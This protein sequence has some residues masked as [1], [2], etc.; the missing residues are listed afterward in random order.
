MA[1]L[2]FAASRPPRRPSMWLVQAG[3]KPTFHAPTVSA[4]DAFTSLMEEEGALDR[5]DS[6]HMPSPS[7][8]APEEGPV[9]QRLQALSHAQ[10]A[11]QHP[12]ASQSIP[13]PTAVLTHG[14][15]PPQHTG[16]SDI[17]FPQPSQLHLQQHH[18]QHQQQAVPPMQVKQPQPQPQPQANQAAL[19]SPFGSA[20]LPLSTRAETGGSESDPFAEFTSSLPLSQPSLPLSQPSLP[21]RPDPAPSWGAFS[22]PATV[23]PT[24]PADD[25]FEDFTTASAGAGAF[26]AGS[27]SS[28]AVEFSA[29][30]SALDRGA[31]LASN[32][33]SGPSASA[34]AS[35]WDHV[36]SGS[37]AN[38]APHFGPLSAQT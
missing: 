17:G 14:P 18:H 38:A 3:P 37:T 11:L 19:L 23:G 7:L 22:S 4:Y 25:E 36:G 33:G 9:P 16:M 32:G 15:M 10:Q 5:S 29:D 27:S 28:A 31:P 20:S 30:F 2:R 8:M 13:Q 34:S 21:S 26:A 35:A 12:G 6:L 24:G 1:G